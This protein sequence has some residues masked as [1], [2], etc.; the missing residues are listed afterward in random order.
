MKSN[1]PRCQ[2]INSFFLVSLNVNRRMVHYPVR[3]PAGEMTGLREVGRI[4][5]HEI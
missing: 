5:E 2:R 1:D 3:I 4:T